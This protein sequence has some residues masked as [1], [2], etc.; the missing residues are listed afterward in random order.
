MDVDRAAVAAAPAAAFEASVIAVA[1]PGT[2]VPL[3]ADADA[4]RTAVV[5]AVDRDA[6][7]AGAAA[8]ETDVDIAAVTAADATA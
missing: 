8:R 3:P 4:R 5:R 7:D 6:T 1:K 2:A